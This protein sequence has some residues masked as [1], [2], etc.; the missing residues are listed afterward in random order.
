MT[1]LRTASVALAIG[2]ALSACGAAAYQVASG[3]VRAEP[4]AAA[5]RITSA[6]ESTYSMALPA[7]WHKVAD[8]A[9]QP[10]IVRYESATGR[11]FEVMVFDDVGPFG[12]D[13]AA[14][15]TWYLGYNSARD[16]F[17]VRSVAPI[18]SAGEPECVAGDGRYEAYAMLKDPSSGETQIDFVRHHVFEF[19]FGG[20]GE[21]GSTAEFR[22]MLSSFRIK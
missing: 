21:N 20:P 13:Y 7:G 17:V 19:D 15:T 22:S 4:L 14:D 8:V 16:G 18:C 11:W 5:P 6:N 9:G 10:G 12:A 3:P 1:S 2:A